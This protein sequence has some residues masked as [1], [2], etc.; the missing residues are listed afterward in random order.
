MSEHDNDYE[1]EEG[2][3]YEDRDDEDYLKQYVSGKDLGSDNNRDLEPP[4]EPPVGGHSKYSGPDDFEYE[5]V[6]LEELPCGIFY[7][8]GIKIMVR[9]A[10]VA[11]IQAYSVVD[12]KNI[13]DI[14]EKMNEMLKTCVKVI[15]PSGKNGSYFDV[16]DAD[17][18]Y[19]IFYIRERTFQSGNNLKLDCECEYCGHEYSVNMM[20][21]SF[22]KGEMPEDLAKYFDSTTRMFHFDLNNAD[23]VSLGLPTIG[24]QKHF[25]EYI[26]D[27]V[28]EEKSPNMAYLKTDPFLIPNRSKISTEGIKKR[29]ID[30]KKMD[31]GTYQFVNGAINKIDDAFGIKEVVSKCPECKEEVHSKMR[32]PGGASALFVI[33]DA[34]DQFI[35]K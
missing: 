11:E 33:P 8:D 15:L 9:A 22:R 19:L 14:T 25:Y 34:F 12:D 7:P 31:P 16:K 1:N 26:K 17:R 3:G 24:I 4:E 35:K 30:F 29:I 28:K 6:P 23:S 21:K 2:F 5:M 32:F 13:Y 10:K 20:R 27:T 18:V